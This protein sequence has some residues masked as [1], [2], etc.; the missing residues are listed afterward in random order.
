ME[1]IHQWHP[2]VQLPCQ[3]RWT[4]SLGHL[5]WILKPL[6][7]QLLHPLMVE[8]ISIIPWH[9]KL[10]HR[11]LLVLLLPQPVP[12]T[13]RM[14]FLILR[15]LRPT[16]S[17]SNCLKVPLDLYIIFL[18]CSDLVLLHIIPAYV[19]F[20]R[21][22]SYTRK[23]FSLWFCMAW[24]PHVCMKVYVACVVVVVWKRTISF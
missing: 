21:Q 22:F 6:E 16:T 23:A 20:P 19:L 5:W 24:A 13:C 14:V 3:C 4:I 8:L 11:L 7:L 15:L 18:H 2:L 1:H 9:I 17:L 10:V 12:L